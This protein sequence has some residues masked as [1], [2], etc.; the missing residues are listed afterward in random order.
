M[1]HNEPNTKEPAQSQ[2]S[3]C[4]RGLEAGIGIFV[5]FGMR[6]AKDAG[7]LGFE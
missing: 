1:I 7:C 6:L 3:N 2:V 4:G 5:N